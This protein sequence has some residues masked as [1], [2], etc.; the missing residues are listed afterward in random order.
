MDTLSYQCSIHQRSHDTARIWGCIWISANFMNFVRTGAN[1]EIFV[2]NGDRKIGVHEKLQQMEPE[3]A[4]ALQH[5]ACKE[6]E[7]YLC[8]KTLL[9]KILCSEILQ[10][11]IKISILV[12]E[13]RFCQIHVKFAKFSSSLFTVACRIESHG[14]L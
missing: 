5:A 1:L 14:R 2:T 7:Y 11:N 3:T 13:L 6:S 10:L 8:I 9:N 12:S 4:T